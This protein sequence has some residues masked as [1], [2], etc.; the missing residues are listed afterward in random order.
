MPSDTSTGEGVGG[1]LGLGPAARLA[2]AGVA[3]SWLALHA[4]ARKAATT[5][6]AAIGDADH[7]NERFMLILRVTES[8]LSNR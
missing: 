1:A 4:V 6:T 2:E 3:R 5:N 8:V 7:L